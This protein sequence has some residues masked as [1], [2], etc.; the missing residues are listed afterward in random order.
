[1]FV[2][3]NVGNLYLTN[4]AG[5]IIAEHLNQHTDFKAPV[6][7]DSEPFHRVTAHRKFACQRISEAIEKIQIFMML[8]VKAV[9]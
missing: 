5:R 9:L 4:S 2:I 6:A 7:R 3:V 1:M 8:R